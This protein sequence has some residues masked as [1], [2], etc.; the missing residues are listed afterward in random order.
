MGTILIQIVFYQMLFLA[1]YEVLLKRDTHYNLQRFYLL[2]LPVVALFLPFI[3]VPSLSETVLESSGISLPAVILGESGITSE[4]VTTTTEAISSTSYSV[5]LI[6]WVV[7]SFISGIWSIWKYRKLHNLRASAS[8]IKKEDYNLV[9]LPNTDVAFSFRNTIYLGEELNEEAKKVILKHEKVHV[10]QKHSIDLVWYQL[11]RIV[12]WWNPF[13]YLF[14]NRLQAVHEYIADAEVVQSITKKEYY[15]SLLSQVFKTN[16]ISFTNTFYKQSLIK[17]RIIMLQKIKSPRRFK[18]KYLLVLPLLAFM[19]VVA[20]CSSDEQVPNSV[21]VTKDMPQPPPP[22][23]LPPLP[24]PPSTPFNE[25]D[26]VPVFPT[27]E[28]NSDL[29]ACMNAKIQEHV[30]GNYNSD[31][32]KELG[33][34]GIQRLEIKFSIDEIGEVDVTY[35]SGP[36]K[37]LLEEARRVV[38]SLPQFIPGEHNGEKVRVAYTLPIVFEVES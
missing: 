7:G 33:L 2:L 21:V 19:L 23:P 32:G 16:N 17:N 38:E 4:T 5:L 10:K 18:L 37:K 8:I 6:L 24:P 26:K 11:L 3:V 35:V 28:G 1:L 31:L 15:Q 14:Q 22:P 9:I 25:V 27:C 36:H 30:V 13:V 12:F 29:I 34:E 20:S